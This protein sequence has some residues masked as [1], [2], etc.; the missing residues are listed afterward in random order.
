MSILEKITTHHLLF[1]I[2]LCDIRER[3]RERERER[4]GGWYG[5]GGLGNHCYK[6]QYNVCFGVVVFASHLPVSITMPVVDT[7]SLSFPEMLV[8]SSKKERSS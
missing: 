8:S 3:E 4:G 5:G 6:I 2:N 7:L 1:C